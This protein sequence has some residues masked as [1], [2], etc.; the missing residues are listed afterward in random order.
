[1]L[2]RVIRVLLIFFVPFLA[3]AASFVANPS[4]ELNYNP[5]VPGYSSINNWT[6]GSGVN[7][8]TGPFHNSGT[9]IPDNVRVAFLQ[10]SGTM[11]QAISGLTPGK[12]YWIQFFYDARSCCAGGSVD[13]STRWNGAL[14]DTITGVAPSSG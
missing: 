7:Q 10:G 3:G 6:G 13:L 12:R 11:S 1:M 14:L 4:F 2:S 5:T 9:P 8:S